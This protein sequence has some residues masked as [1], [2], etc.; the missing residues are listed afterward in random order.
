MI[1][2]DKRNFAASWLLVFWFGLQWT[3]AYAADSVSTE[4]LD[5]RRK[6]IAA[7]S[8]EQRQELIRKYHQ[9][10]KLTVA[11]RQKLHE[12]HKAVESDPKLKQVMDQYC[13]WLRGLDESQRK[14]LRDAQT[15]EQK[16]NL[17]RRFYAAQS[18]RT[19]DFLPNDE[20]GIP[21]KLRPGFVPVLSS[22]G[23]K[24][25]MAAVE[26]ALIEQSVLNDRMR[27]K[28]AQVDGSLRY[29]LLM[30]AI[31]SYRH[32]EDAAIRDLPLP[33]SVKAAF[34]KAIRDVDSAPKLKEF[35]RHAKDPRNQQHV[36]MTTLLPS[37][38]DEA[39]REFRGPDAAKYKESIVKSLPKDKLY[40]YE[41]APEKERDKLLL[42]AHVESI[43]RSF[44]KAGD[45][46]QRVDRDGPWRG[47][48]GDYPPRDRDR[49]GDNPRQFP[50]RK[51]EQ[52]RQEG[53]R[54]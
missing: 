48:P 30:E 14:Q 20:P 43:R 25:V 10:Q 3:T 27:S 8:G 19:E 28:I 33:E 42:M 29:K 44:F 2:L 17:V 9:Y 6:E 5:Q 45:L 26:A 38:V 51:P 36:F 1:L 11:E 22:E 53:R 15:P 18:Q 13:E 37:T 24:S 46:Q 4:V 52:A 7:R 16:R 34:E 12:L 21:P 49:E 32:P 39:H 23:L 35:W 40:L 50:G 31:A 41:H 47:R 54:P